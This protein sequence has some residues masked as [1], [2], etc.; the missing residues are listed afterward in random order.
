MAGNH[1]LHSSNQDSKTSADNKLQEAE[2]GGAVEVDN[3][4]NDGLHDRQ[5]ENEGGASSIEGSIDRICVLL[6][7]GKRHEAG[8]ACCRRGSL[9]CSLV[10]SDL[11][12]LPQ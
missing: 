9:F 3:E 2:K 7:S 6:V 8:H 11:E 10:N 1:L 4:V 12:F 5:R